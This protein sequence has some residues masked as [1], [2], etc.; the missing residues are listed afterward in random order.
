M[1]DTT[2]DLATHDPEARAREIGPSLAQRADRIEAARTLPDDVVQ[3][4][5]AADMFRTFIPVAYGGAETDILTGMAALTELGRWDGSTAWCVMIAN[6][7][8]L[9][10]GYL[11]PE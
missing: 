2:H 5:L 11:P 3:D 1:T 8:A 10:A 6:T 9:L 4:L 7:T